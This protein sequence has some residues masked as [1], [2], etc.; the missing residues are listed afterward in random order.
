MTASSKAI[1]IKKLIIDSYFCVDFRSKYESY[2]HE[3]IFYA[4]ENDEICF[5]Q[6]TRASTATR[7]KENKNRLHRN[8]AMDKC[9]FRVR[10]KD[11]LD[12]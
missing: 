4:T 5:C 11:S 8:L 2:V 6:S 7:C 10:P 1:T 3:T 12:K 9:Y